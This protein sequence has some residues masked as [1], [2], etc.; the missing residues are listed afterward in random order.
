MAEVQTRA[1]QDLKRAADHIRLLESSPAGVKKNYIRRVKQFPVLVMTVGLAQALAFSKEKAS[2]TT[3]LAKAH[4]ALLDQ[5]GDLLRVQNPNI[6]DSVDA[7]QKAT[8]AEY[9]HYTR[10]VLS[11]WMYYRRFAVSILDPDGK[12]QA[13]GD[14][15]E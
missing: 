12:L 6:Q 13:E 3:D 1:Q 5:V 7:V 9:L 4:R 15:E 14:D 8:T 2:K 10:R 11:A